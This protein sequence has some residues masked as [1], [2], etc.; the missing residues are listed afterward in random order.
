MDFKYI[1]STFI[2]P[3]IPLA[4][5]ILA[6]LLG[7][8]AYFRQKEYE[9]ITKRYLEEGIDSISKN[10]DSSLAII[11]H[12]WWHCLFVLKSFRDLGKDMRPELYNE[13]LIKPDPSNFELWK[14]YRLKDIVGNDIFNRVHQHLDS[15]V[16]S[17][18]S[19]FRDDMC[20]GI[21]VTL[22]G[23]KELEV[24]ATREEI[25][26]GI[27]KDAIEIDNK[28]R[29]F[30]VLLGELQ[31]ISN[32]IQTKRISFK[33]LDKLK[34]HTVVKNAVKN[35]KNAVKEVLKDSD[36]KDTKKCRTVSFTRL[37][38]SL[39]VQTRKVR[40]TADDAGRYTENAHKG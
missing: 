16:K 22:N 32:L 6:Y 33:N 17:S 1:F 21:R 25:Y 29:K 24:V 3:L 34:E 9:L 23:G 38:R 37:S 40:W 36:S 27:L 30:Y 4:A 19:S 13:G 20:N 5:V 28:A 31:N 39:T 18:F 12:N 8:S 2:S 26:E 7:K 15:F 11:R 14:D 35:L 10:V